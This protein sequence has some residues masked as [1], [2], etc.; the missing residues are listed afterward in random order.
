VVDVSR[1][2]RL[3]L[4]LA[5]HCRVK[6]SMALRL[7]FPTAPTFNNPDAFG[8]A[9][10]SQ[11]VVIKNDH[12]DVVMTVADDG[13]GHVSVS[14]PGALSVAGDVEVSGALSLNGSHTIID[15]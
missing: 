15:V 8:R 6:G 5:T 12:N 9:A 7:E 3:R 10:I 2:K 1:R 4:R 14:V 11:S 13:A